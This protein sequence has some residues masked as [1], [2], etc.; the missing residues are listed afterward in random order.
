MPA[1]CPEP[2][3][4][5]MVVVVVG[6]WAA[7]WGVGARSGAAGRS[8]AAARLPST[9]GLEGHHRWCNCA[10]VWGNRTRA[11]AYGGSVSE[12]WEETAGGEGMPWEEGFVRL[13]WQPQRPQGLGRPS[14]NTGANR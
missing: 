2:L 13:L 1:A 7:Q 3:V 8:A 10:P 14:R 11:C 9:G 5:I 4:W 12:D 6:V